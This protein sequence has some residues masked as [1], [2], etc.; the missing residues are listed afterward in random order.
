MVGIVHW[1]A[2]LRSSASALLVVRRSS[3]SLVRVY[4]SA[5][6]LRW[7]R[8]VRVDNND[9]V[10]DVCEE[11]FGVRS[12]S[13]TVEKGPGSCVVHDYTGRHSVVVSDDE[14]AVVAAKVLRRLFQAACW[15]VADGFADRPVEFGVVRMLL[16]DNVPLE[17]IISACEVA[18]AG[19]VWNGQ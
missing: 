8:F 2:E 5:G 4:A 10:G 3:R 19:E 16:D 18:F 9:V 7:E 1:L 11:L 13:V 15:S 6:N 14:F 12:D 17:R